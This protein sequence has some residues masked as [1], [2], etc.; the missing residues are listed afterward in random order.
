MNRQKRFSKL[1]AA[2]LTL[3]MVLMLIPGGFISPLTARAAETYEVTSTADG[4]DT[5]VGTLR[6]AIAQVN[7]GS[8][9]DTI[10]I[11]PAREGQTITL[12]SD[13]PRIEKA[14]TING[15]NITISGNNERRIFSIYRADVT[16]K[17][18]TFTNGFATME[19]GAI[20]NQQ[21]NLTVTDCIFT[22]NI[23]NATNFYGG[24]VYSG[25]G[26]T[27]TTATFVNCLFANNSAAR[28]GAVYYYG[29]NGDG[30][31]F[32]NCTFTADNTATTDGNIFDYEN[33]DSGTDPQ[34]FNCIIVNAANDK[35]F[36]SRD[37]IKI[38]D[39]VIFKN[40]L[41]NVASLGGNAANANNKVGITSLGLNA[42]WTL[43]LNSPAINA[44]DGSLYPNAANSTDLAG[45]P[46][47]GGDSIDI[48]AYEYYDAMPIK[49]LRPETTVSDLTDEYGAGTTVIDRQN[50][51][52]T[53]EDC[54]GTGAVITL[55][56]R[57]KRAVIVYGDLIGNGS[58]LTDSVVALARHI[59][60]L[61]S[62]DG[63]A[64]LLEAADV[65][66]DGR[67]NIADLIRLARYIAKID[68][69]NLGGF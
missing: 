43:T 52:L 23:V 8:G 35:G 27:I 30:M 1:L 46:R 25:H 4:T 64:L 12:T 36:I 9:G 68:T 34:F 42:D 5:D 41:T 48:G 45:N 47:I 58:V 49:I 11:D 24:A 20:Y 61:E 54:V 28:G 32:V 21:G 57:S 38:I 17:R 13:L 53:S 15:N 51:T 10:N 26:T 6:W 60:G 44:G 56:N 37:D 40:T 66:G 69:S 31:T 7:A 65:N 63:D 19:G 67:I 50:E 22:G 39:G 33:Y 59:A 16:I 62:L 18:I 2:I 29:G 3:A 55:P 14:L